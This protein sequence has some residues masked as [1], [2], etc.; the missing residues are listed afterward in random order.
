M[1]PR[2]LRSL[3]VFRGLSVA[4]MIVVNHP[5]NWLTVAPFLAHSAWNGFTLADLVFPCFIVI[6]GMAIPLVLSRRLDG[7]PPPMGPIVRRAAVLVALGLALNA[8]HAW[9]QLASIRIPGVLQRIALTYLGAMLLARRLSP[10]QQLW[11][12]LWLMGG[13]WALLALWPHP[14]GPG[15]GLLPGH[16]LGLS[17]DRA[18]F[19]SHLLA[20]TG[21]PEGLI[22]LP[23]SIATALLGVH[24]GRLLTRPQH[25][26]RALRT[27]VW[28]GAG[29]VAA[30]TLWSVVWPMNK[31]LWSGSYATFAAGLALLLFALCYRFVDLVPSP[32]SWSWPFEAIGR[33][34]LGVYVASELTGTLLERPW[35]GR[36]LSPKDVLFWRWLAPAIGDHGGARSSFLYAALFA[37]LWIGMAMLWEA[38]AA[39]RR[40]AA[41]GAA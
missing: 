15:G 39:H 10:R 6:M 7:A 13:Q 29:L 11:S 17:L 25:G 12:V 34:A 38:A 26:Q 2:R 21:D 18:I 8:A 32:R 41:V 5:G 36:S 14:G 28:T 40:R 3:D 4:G 33:H 27:L 37:A 24:A 20:P 22:G 30:G 1:K 16:H 31:S 23:T 35:F 9:P 19:G